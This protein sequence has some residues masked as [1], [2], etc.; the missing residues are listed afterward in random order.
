LLHTKSNGTG[1]NYLV[2]H[3][4][5]SGKSNSIS[6]LTHRLS[7]LHNENDD[8]IFDSIIV[9][10]DRLVLDQQ[11]QNTV[12]QFEHKK[13]VV[14]KID[15]D[16]KQL[17]KAL[18]NG[19]PII[20]TTIQKFPFVTEALEKLNEDNYDEYKLST[21]GKK[22]AVIIDEAHS[23]QSGETSATL[24]GVLNKDGIKEAA[25][26][27]RSENG[28]DDSE[29][30]IIRQMMKR[31]KQPN[32]SFYAFTATPKYKTKHLFD[33]PGS[34]GKS[35]FH[36]YSM[37]QAIE[38]NFIIDVLENYTTY[39]TYF[40]IIK[41][42]AD[43]PK[44]EKR[45][46]AK[47]LA[48]FLTMHPVN[49][50]QKIEVI[51]EHFRQN[52][53]HKI[54]GRAKAMVVTESRLNAVNYKLEFDK[55]I[56]KKG[57]S[58]IKSLVAFSG[59]V[60]DDKNNEIK[61][62]EVGM[63]NGI[64]E[65]ELPDKFDSNEYQVLLVA[66]KYQTG[67]DQPYLHTMYVDKKLSGVQAVQTLSR[68]NRT[69]T[70]KEE[71][72]VLD[73]RNTTEEI[74]EAFKPY[75]E[76]TPTDELIDSQHLYRLESQL[77]EYNIFFNEDIEEFNKVYFKQ[78]R[79]LSVND[80]AQLHKIIDGVKVNFNK[81]DEE[82][83]ESFRSLL[84]NFKNMYGFLSQVIPFQ[85]SDLEKLYTFVRYL[86][87]KIKK[88]DK[89]KHYQF[90]EEVALQ[91]YRLQKI[92]EGS[93]TLN[94]GNASSLK[95]PGDVGTGKDDENVQLSELIQKLNDRFGTNFTQADQ[96]FFDQIHEEAKQDD[97]LKKAAKVN[98]LDDFKYVY[99]KAFDNLVID[100]REGN[101]AIFARLM[102]DADFRSIAFQNL[103][104]KLYNSFN[105]QSNNQLSID[106]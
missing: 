89:G 100:R 10:T 84:V 8:K 21:K 28:M 18:V 24:K 9:V 42:I 19:T 62:T 50:G 52:V 95:G 36:L 44:V 98:S 79:N 92:S 74:F 64:K 99:E 90:D 61:Y 70:G 22:F 7:T 101:E 75:Y 65:K 80:N 53:M 97:D 34:D 63:N 73:F 17:V 102:K 66:D 45:K 59:T 48:R 2:Q 32:L 60:I 6:W 15:E 83:Q 13:G 72:F 33:E 35:P 86:I 43:D 87:T 11:L 103:L 39:K 5:G 1:K 23:S 82:K 51:V 104:H 46:A 85:D 69:C 31:G 96:L 106:D 77:L 26:E 29:D 68:L 78:K 40:K 3:S 93:I 49:I 91:Y 20:V 30:I 12:Y 54:G 57:Y 47:A 41:S 37:R 88:D 38:E 4:A 67:F 94:T 76:K 58:G 27:Y 71:T 55:Y 16:T 14:Q 25:K 105:E 81:L 56:R